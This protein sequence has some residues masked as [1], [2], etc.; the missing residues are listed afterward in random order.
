[1]RNRPTPEHYSPTQ[2]VLHWVVLIGVITQIAL[3]EPIVRVMAAFRAG[4]A[5]AAGDMNFAWIHVTVGSTILVCVLAR[6]YL[7]LRQGAPR[8][9]PGTPP[10][11]AKLASIV[12][13]MLYA[14]L[15]AIV[16]TG[17]LTWNRIASLGGLHF[18]LT[19]ALVLLIAG[20]AA[21]AL[22]NQFVRKDGTLLRM[23]RPPE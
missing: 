16:A 15:L 8:H 17:L 4:E 18:G 23:T 5:P 20:H 7:R 10:L 2:I 19:V 13:W 14:L 1:M 6:I 3:H 9:A 11:V 22:Y 21:A 12:H